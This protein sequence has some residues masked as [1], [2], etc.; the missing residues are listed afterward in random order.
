MVPKACPPHESGASPVIEDDTA[1]AAAVSPAPIPI[2]ANGP[3]GV[4]L[5][6]V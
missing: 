5:V 3:S 2:A 1:F 4:L 6:R